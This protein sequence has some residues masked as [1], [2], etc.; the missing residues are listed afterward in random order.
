MNTAYDDEER[1]VL[2]LMQEV[3]V[4]NKHVPGLSAARMEMRNQ[5]HARSHNLECPLFSLQLIL[6]MSITLW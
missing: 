6:L 4:I 3:R 1:R 2:Q 5:I